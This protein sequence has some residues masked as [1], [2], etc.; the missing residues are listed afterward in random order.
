MSD[1]IVIA[2]DDEASAFDVRAELVRMQQEYLLQLEDAVVVT[3]TGGE[4]QLHQPVNMTAA[5]A[6]G[7]TMWGAL[8]GLIFLNPL[9]GA[10]VGGLSGALAGRFTDI[11]INDDFIRRVSQAVPPGGSAVF[12][13]IRKMT[14]DKVLARLQS[15]HAR[16]RILQSS[17][18]DD[19]ETRLRD[20]LGGDRHHAAV[21]DE[22]AGEPTAAPHLR[23]AHE[24]E[25]DPLPN[26]R[27]DVPPAR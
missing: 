18:P 7:G 2:F 12:L 13:L 25:L 10:A 6:A 4:V 21:V 20:A 23:P 19:V 16:G 27:P 24:A 5:G 22:G 15:F 1:L 14:T 9:A 17:L 26:T 3:R 8:V 11:G